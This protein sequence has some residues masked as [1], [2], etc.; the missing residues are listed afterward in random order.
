MA[1]WEPPHTVV[2]EQRHYPELLARITQIADTFHVQIFTGSGELLRATAT[3]RASAFAKA[4]ELLVSIN[5]HC[6]SCESWE[7]IAVDPAREP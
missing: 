2:L 4:A 6:E 3:T 7:V 1:V 5:H